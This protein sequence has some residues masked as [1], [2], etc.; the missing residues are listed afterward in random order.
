MNTSGDLEAGWE[1]L[2]RTEKRVIGLVQKGLTN[3]EIAA[4]LYVS[5]RT[6][7]THLY[8]V[9]KKVGVS[10][11]AELAREAAARGITMELGWETSN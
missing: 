8:N 1:T 5:P 4:R 10:S 2:S 9:F 7:Q 11:R 3:P 6:V